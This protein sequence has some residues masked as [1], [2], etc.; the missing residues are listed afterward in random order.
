MAVEGLVTPDALAEAVK[1]LDAEEITGPGGLM[2]QAAGRV[3][4]GAWALSSLTISAV[5]MGRRPRAAP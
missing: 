4:E 5:K 3:I 1:R 2:T